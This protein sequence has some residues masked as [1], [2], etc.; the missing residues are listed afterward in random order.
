MAV[1]S[2]ER[3]EL[4]DPVR[5]STIREGGQ[6]SSEEGG[7]IRMKGSFSKQTV[8]LLTVSAVVTAALGG[9]A[10]LAETSGVFRDDGRAIVEY[11]DAGRT[12]LQEAIEDLK[13]AL[14]VP[15]DL[16]ESNEGA[17]GALP[18]DPAQVDLVLKLSQCYFTLG[19][20][21]LQGQEGE[22]D[23]YVRGKDWGL[24][25]LRLDPQFAA[26]ERTA[27]FVEAV[28]NETNAVALYWAALNWLS[29]ANFDPIGA[30]LGGVAA[31]TVAMLE[32][33]AD[34]DPPYDCYGAFRVLGS[35][36]GA[37]PRLPFGTYRKNLEQAR[38]YLC[39]VVEDPSLCA[40]LDG[41]PADPT[42]VEYLGNRRVFAEFYLMEKGL[43]TDAAQV[44][45]SILDAPIGDIYPLY[46]ARAQDD[47]RRLLEEVDRHL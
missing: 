16:D 31:K 39:R 33:V 40:D 43:W 26:I 8:L 29:V 20:I 12:Q 38:S 17:V 5:W 44:L 28:E 35:I 23:A 18:V 46:N 9:A 19:V 45:Q 24:K 37:L 2:W 47:A 11:S 15:E 13:K 6:S 14:D 21:F 10:A 22:S 7:A 30:V 34:L 27:G 4:D 42:C 41:S 36:W 32:R 25:G 3:S 1:A